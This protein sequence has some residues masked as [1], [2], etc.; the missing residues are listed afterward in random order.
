MH[1]YEKLPHEYAPKHK[2]QSVLKHTLRIAVLLLLFLACKKTPERVQ[3]TVGQITES[4]YASGI[5]KSQ[6]QY[7][8]YST[9]GG[10]VQKIWVKEGAV[11][12]QGDP[13]FTI[14]SE[15]ARLGAE[16]AQLAADFTEMN[17]RGERLSE[18]HSAIETARS[19]MLHDSLLLTR[20]QGLW[21]QQIGS[22]V[23]LEQ[24]ELAYT[25]STNNYEAALLRYKDLQ[26]QLQFAA[27]QAKKQLSISQNN[28][29]DYIIRSQ[30]DGRVYS[31]ARELGEIV[32]TQAPV[33]VIGDADQ[34]IAELQVDESDI[35]RIKPGQRTLL[36]MD[37]Y[38]GQVLEAVIV[39]LD[40]LMN[41]R[42]RTFTV[43]ATF[44][45]KPPT[46]YP[47]LSA[48][49]NIIIQSR[50]N[51]LTIPRAYLL[52]DSTVLLSN[53]EKRKVVTGL[54]DYQKV[55]IVRGLDATET[56]VKPVK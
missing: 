10:L 17:T 41:E 18:L 54:K 52:D 39:Q 9:V 19:K 6:N 25:T 51:A 44:T 11:V 15:T 31:I 47:Y 5:I 29:R 30:T 1:R 26:K 13:L 24:R 27:A 16:N 48:E 28:A 14:Q 53:E 55:E 38:K 34:F 21:A 46:L 4:V 33:A 32:N 37:S 22:K 20:Q 49:A 23:E 43:E 7:Q 35:A 8:V 3:P 56:I 45:Q 40:P 2:K 42:T 12:R 50:E 36:T